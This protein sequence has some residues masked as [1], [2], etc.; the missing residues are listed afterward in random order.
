M[1]REKDIQCNNGK[2]KTLNKVYLNIHKIIKIQKF[3]LALFCRAR[4][5]EIA[6][7]PPFEKCNIF[8]QF[9]IE[10]MIKTNA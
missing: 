1:K 9:A 6:R 7:A 2:R 10:L 8:L 3:T 4:D 5:F